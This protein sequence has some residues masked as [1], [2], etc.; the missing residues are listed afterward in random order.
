MVG[1]K[2]CATI[3]T[4]LVYM[5]PVVVAIKECFMLG[6]CDDNNNN[7]NNIVTMWPVVCTVVVCQS[8]LAG[9]EW[10]LAQAIVDSHL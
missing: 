7:N 1:Q 8:I 6:L 2:F 9:V 5:A 3:A 10:A 4:E